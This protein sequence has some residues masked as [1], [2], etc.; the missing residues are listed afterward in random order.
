MTALTLFMLQPSSLWTHP[1]FCLVWLRPWDRVATSAAA[2]RQ[3]G[4][5]GVARS[6]QWLECEALQTTGTGQGV[7]LGLV[8]MSDSGWL[9]FRVDNA[10]S[11]T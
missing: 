5:A 10:Q 1:R 3:K 11:S 8:M 7:C 4:L 9:S 2:T 6:L